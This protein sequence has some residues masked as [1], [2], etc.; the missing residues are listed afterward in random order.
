MTPLLILMLLGI[1]GLALSA[2]W[3]WT[4]RKAAAKYQAEVDRQAQRANQA[5]TRIAGMHKLATNLEQLQQKQR[6]ETI[7]ASTPQHLD[8]RNDFDNDWSDRMPESTAGANH[9]GTADTTAAS[10]AAG[11]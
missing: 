8:L 6:A 9:S 3:I 10:G 2:L 1:A 5:E 4:Y 11:D 7:N